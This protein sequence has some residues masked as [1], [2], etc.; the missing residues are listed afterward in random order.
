M[1]QIHTSS[2]Y[3]QYLNVSFLIV[4]FFASNCESNSNITF[5]IVVSNLF[6]FFFL[7]SVFHSFDLFLLLLLFNIVVVLVAWLVVVVV[8]F[9]LSSIFK[10]KYLAFLHIFICVC[11]CHTLC[12]GENV[13][14]DV[15]MKFNLCTCLSKILMQKGYIGTWSNKKKWMTTN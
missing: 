11:V 8:R 2:Y 6:C 10:I 12:G 4:F 5:W 7:F 15:S 3:S 1:Y 13:D 14:V 9:F